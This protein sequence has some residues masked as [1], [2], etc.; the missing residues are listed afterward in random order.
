MGNASNCCKKSN[1]QIDCSNFDNNKH[2]MLSY[3][4]KYKPEI[5]I[6]VYEYLTSLG[7][8]VWMDRYNKINSN[9]NSQLAHAVEKSSILIRVL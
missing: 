3:S 6:Q 7:Y 2:I 5:V 9:L 4:W 1:N 8:T